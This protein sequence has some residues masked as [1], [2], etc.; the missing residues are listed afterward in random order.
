MKSLVNLKLA[1]NRAILAPYGAGRLLLIANR[2][3]RDFAPFLF[4][5][6]RANRKNG[7]VTLLKVTELAEVTGMPSL[8]QV[9]ARNQPA[10]AER[11]GI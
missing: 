7:A 1:G 3:T 8:E 6:N 2:F 10:F 4:P 9:A 5:K 11:K